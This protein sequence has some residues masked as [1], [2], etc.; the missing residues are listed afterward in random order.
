MHNLEDE[1]LPF[2]ALSELCCLRLDWP[3]TLITCMS[4]YQFDLDQMRKECRE[5]FGSTQSGV[6]TICGKQIQ[7]NLGRHV[8]SHGVKAVNLA[9]WFPPWTVTRGQWSSMTRPAV[10]GIAVD[11]LLFSR[12]GMPLLHRY[13][14]FDRPGT[15]V[16]FRGTYMQRLRTFLEESD[17]ASV[18]RHHRRCAR[19]IAAR[20]SRT[21]L[22]DTSDR[23]LDVSARP[24]VSRQSV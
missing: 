16:A 14:V 5:R 22:R 23:T 2:V 17:E 10:S 19:E 11:A 18:R 6:C 3:R 21:S 20:M 9:R 8:I 7:K 1:E 15:H 4:R 13:W 24:R 12:I